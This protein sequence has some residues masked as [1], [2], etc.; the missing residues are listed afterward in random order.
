ME[1]DYIKS[2]L[3]NNGKYFPQEKLRSINEE[4]GKS[5]K[6]EYSINLSF[7]NPTLF[8]V[9]YW[10]VPLFWFLDRFFTGDYFG[11]MIKLSYILMAYIFLLVFGGSYNY[12]NDNLNFTVLFPFILYFIWVMIDGITLYKRIKNYNHRKLMKAIGRKVSNNDNTLPIVMLIILLF[13][14]GYAYFEINSINF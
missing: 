11:A 8:A 6:A 4:L 5:K 10:F 7:R 12:T 9:M 1:K 14:I 2:Y 13:L 3:L